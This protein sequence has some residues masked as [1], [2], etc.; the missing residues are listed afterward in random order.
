MTIDKKRRAAVL[1]LAGIILSVCV[2]LFALPGTVRTA[3]GESGLNA[4]YMI[5]TRIEI[6]ARELEAGGETADA[7]SRLKAAP[8]LVGKLAL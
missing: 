1:I 2:A 7:V 8:R 6:P 4:S 5:G 3:W